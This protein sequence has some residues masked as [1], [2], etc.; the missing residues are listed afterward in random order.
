MIQQMGKAKKKGEA[1]VFIL[2]TPKQTKIK[3]SNKIEKRIN[4]TFSS[5]FAN[6][7]LSNS[8]CPKLPSKI[9]PLNQVVNANK[10]KLRNLKLI[11]GSQADLDIDKGADLFD[12]ATD[13]DQ[14]Q[15]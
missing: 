7:Q 4:G 12:L 15:L 2:F 9:S 13:V 10:S 1:S 8:N 3:D 6:A 14:D 5:I 11:A